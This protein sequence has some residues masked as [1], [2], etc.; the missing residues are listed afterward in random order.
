MTKTL[1]STIGQVAATIN[2]MR[3]DHDVEEDT[4]VV[5]FFPNKSR[6]FDI[7]RDVRKRIEADGLTDDDINEIIEEAR[8]ESHQL[9]TKT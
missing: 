1:E 5:I 2:Q 7:R 4:T 3:L 6:L 9:I 8:T